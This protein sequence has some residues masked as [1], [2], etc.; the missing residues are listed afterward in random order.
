MNGK[1]KS[2]A[3]FRKSGNFKDQRKFPKIVS[4]AY[5]INEDN[6]Q[7]GTKKALAKLYI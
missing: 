3:D 7:R 2:P 4:A 5:N 1:G 6:T